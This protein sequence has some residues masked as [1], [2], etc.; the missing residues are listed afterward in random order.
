MTI[1]LEELEKLVELDL[2][3]L[4]KEKKRNNHGHGPWQGTIFFR[5][6]CL[7]NLENVPLFTIVTFFPVTIS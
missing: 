4:R 5:P 1:M 2:P 6:P 3:P 7:R